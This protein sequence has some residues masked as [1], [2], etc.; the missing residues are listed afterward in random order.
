[1][2]N[3]AEDPSQTL[4]INQTRLVDVLPRRNS[5]L[6]Q[7]AGPLDW[8]CNQTEFI[9]RLLSVD[10]DIGPIDPKFFASPLLGPIARQLGFPPSTY[11]SFADN[12]T[13][14]LV[15]SR[16][17]HLANWLTGEH[18]PEEAILGTLQ[19]RAAITNRVTSGDLAIPVIIRSN[20]I[21]DKD[22]MDQLIG[23]GRVTGAGESQATK[24]ICSILPPNTRVIGIMSHLNTYYTYIFTVSARGSRNT[25]IILFDPSP[26]DAIDNGCREVL[27]ELAKG[28]GCPSQIQVQ[29]YGKILVSQL[30]HSPSPSS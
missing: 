15:H 2:L 6:P 25:V 22:V 16:L 23:M 5:A 20:Q 4:W 26:G 27:T 14:Y 8:N 17:R 3:R 1:V 21:P 9:K 10:L 19:T 24:G 7:A 29:Y 12:R 28:Y 13:Q 11:G 30:P 18:C